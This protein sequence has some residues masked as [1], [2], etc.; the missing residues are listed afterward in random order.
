MRAAEECIPQ[1]L[2]FFSACS[3][4]RACLVAMVASVSPS[5]TKTLASKA[6]S[7]GVH[8]QASTFASAA[9][10][11]VSSSAF[12]AYLIFIYY[13]KNGLVHPSNR[14]RTSLKRWNLSHTS[15]NTASA[16]QACSPRRQERVG[17]EIHANSQREAYRA[18]F[19]CRYVYRNYIIK[20]KV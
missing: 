3:S 12:M 6:S 5:W 1:R 15:P 10:A 16:E 18:Q 4:H 13:A 2:L 17:R 9:K 11:E 8:R 7:L 14:G 20:N 19:V